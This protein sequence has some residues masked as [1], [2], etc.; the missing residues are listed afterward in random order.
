ML[1]TQRM[2]QEVLSLLDQHRQQLVPREAQ[3][4]NALAGCFAKEKRI[5]GQ[6]PCMP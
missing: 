5:A 4:S 3:T 1:V 2:A 6:W